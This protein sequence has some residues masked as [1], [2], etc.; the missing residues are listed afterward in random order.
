MLQNTS[1]LHFFFPPDNIIGVSLTDYSH[2]K[3]GGILGQA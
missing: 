3:S 1:C 2:Y